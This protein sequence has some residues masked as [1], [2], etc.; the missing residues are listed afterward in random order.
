M[1]NSQEFKIFLLIFLPTFHPYFDFR[2]TFLKSRQKM[3]F[4]TPIPCAI[5]NTSPTL[6]SHET[7]LIDLKE[8]VSPGSFVTMQNT[9]IVF[10]V[11]E[12]CSETPIDLTERALLNPSSQGLTLSTFELKISLPNGLNTTSLRQRSVR[13][14]H[15]LV[16][17]NKIAYALNIDL[18]SIYFVFHADAIL[19]GE[20]ECDSIGNSYL[21]RYEINNSHNQIEM[22]S[23]NSFISLHLKFFL[24][25]TQQITVFKFGHH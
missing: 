10:Q 8:Y 20:Y 23:P 19:L 3:A 18:N 1:G 25:I 24:F 6:S 15:E 5:S 11:I 2:S 9:E 16:K 22:I 12:V 13:N 4:T 17:M 21:I 7:Y 14:V